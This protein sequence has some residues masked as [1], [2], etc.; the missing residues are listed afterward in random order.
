[1]NFGLVILFH[2]TILSCMVFDIISNVIKNNVFF[3]QFTIWNLVGLFFDPTNRLIIMNNII[4][5]ILFHSCLIFE[6]ELIV[7]IP[8]KCNLSM[9]NFHMANIVLHI[10]P[11]F[12]S[13]YMIYNY[14]IVFDIIDVF[15]NIMFAVCWQFYVEFDYSIYSI[16]KQY[17][18]NLYLIYLSCLGGFLVW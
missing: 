10:L 14:N 6:P 15:D 1:M 11:L 8:K 9:N 3:K 7:T 4:V 12:Y 5:F 2:K 17:Y 13:M 16:S 18:F